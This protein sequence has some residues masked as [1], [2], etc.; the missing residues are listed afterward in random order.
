[1]SP[2]PELDTGTFSWLTRDYQGAPGSAR[3]GFL[4]D[5]STMGAGLHLQRGVHVL[6]GRGGTG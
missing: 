6:R 2:S 5:F 3:D 4:G 1:M